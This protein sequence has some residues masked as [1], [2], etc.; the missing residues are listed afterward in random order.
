LDLYVIREKRAAGL[1]MVD[2][3]LPKDPEENYY[4]VAHAGE[5]TKIS[6][7]E[8]GMLASSDKQLDAENADLVIG[9]SGLL[10]CHGLR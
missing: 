9:E 10:G 1:Y 3:D 6:E 2:P 8:E 4:F 7:Q 5:M